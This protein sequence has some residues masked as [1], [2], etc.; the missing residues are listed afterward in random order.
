MRNYIKDARMR[1][2]HL[3]RSDNLGLIKHVDRVYF[4]TKFCPSIVFL[5]AASKLNI[6]KRILTNICALIT[7]VLDKVWS[8]FLLCVSSGPSQSSC[9]FVCTC[10]K[11]ITLWHS[12]F[13][14][15]VS[16][17]AN[18]P[19]QLLVL[20]H[21]WLSQKTLALIGFNQNLQLDVPNELVGS[22]SSNVVRRSWHHSW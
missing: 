9:T 19:V 5:P 17:G 12:D 16:G 2:W 22:T 18:S 10:W 11:K 20:A 7:M 21:C 3:F 4:Q 14:K 1:L 8:E 6:L 15:Q 13:V